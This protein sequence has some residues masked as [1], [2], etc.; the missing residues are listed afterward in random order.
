MGMDQAT[1]AIEPVYPLRH[2]AA[3]VGLF[4]QFYRRHFGRESPEALNIIRQALDSTVAGQHLARLI[5]GKRFGPLVREFS[6]DRTRDLASHALWD[7]F[8]STDEVSLDLQRRWQD[9]TER[10]PS[11]FYSRH[12]DNDVLVDEEIHRRIAAGT[13]PP[14]RTD[15]WEDLRD[16][17]AVRNRE[18]GLLGLHDIDRT[19]ETVAGQMSDETWADYLVTTS[20]GSVL[21]IPREISRPNFLH[22]SPGRF[23]SRG[24]PPHILVRGES[25]KAGQQMAYVR[26]DDLQLE[27]GVTGAARLH[28]DSFENPVG[29]VRDQGSW[30]VVSGGV[31]VHGALSDPR[32]GHVYA[33]AQVL[34]RNR[35]HVF[36]EY[37]IRVQREIVTARP[38]PFGSRHSYDL[39][40]HPMEQF[41]RKGHE[42]VVARRDWMGASQSVHVRTKHAMRDLANNQFHVGEFVHMELA[43]KEGSHEGSVQVRLGERT[44]LMPDIDVQRMHPGMGTMMIEWLALEAKAQGRDFEILFA[45]NPRVRQI[46]LRSDV[47][48]VDRAR[49]EV[50]KRE[51]QRPYYTRQAT[52]RLDDEA[53]LKQFERERHFLNIHVAHHDGELHKLPQPELRSVRMITSRT[54]SIRPM[55]GV[56]GKTMGRLKRGTFV[57]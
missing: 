28:Q 43:V 36:S 6:Y 21:N 3:V 19:M 8:Q 53:G 20:S 10:R 22:V 15:R 2:H 25:I 7:V 12:R 49:M 27:P 35:E 29:V 57:K 56:V 4:D 23:D 26:V 34:P 18:G 46:V 37:P 32:S 39:R 44:L 38:T 30:Q 1:K 31:R 11:L 42:E 50:W 14:R 9:L 55:G 54:R 52:L 48:D 16:F 40:I 33:Y 45:V 5:E 17:Y 47:I 24:A 41:A 51:G 13:P